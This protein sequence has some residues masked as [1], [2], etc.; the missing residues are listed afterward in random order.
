LSIPA[1]IGRFEIHEALGAG[2]MG[3]VYRAHD[4]RLDR[5]VALKVLTDGL[6]AGIDAVRRFEQEARAASSL[7]H[8]NI[9]TVFD[10]GIDGHTAYIVT[11]L[12]QGTTLRERL[13]RR[14]IAVDAMLDIAVQIAAGLSAAH[15][16]GIV[17]RDV[18]PQN[19][20]VTRTGVVK[21]LDFGVAR[22]EKA[23]DP[24]PVDDT[25]PLAS[26]TGAG[27]VLGTPAYMAPEQIRGQAADARADI[28]AFGCVLHEMMCGTGPFERATPADAMAAVLAEAPPARPPHVGAPGL[29]RIVGRC[30]EKDPTD[31]FQSAADL[32][33]ALEA[34]R[35]A[36]A[37]PP[38]SAVAHRATLPVAVLAGLALIAVAVVTGIWVSRDS[39]PPAESGPVVIHATTV[40]P[41]SAR[42]IAPAVAP[43]GK[44]VAYVG[45]AGG[46]PDV[47]V[48]YLNA[49]PPV[50]LTSGLDLPLQTR[51]V[52]GGIDVLPDGSGIAVAGRGPSGCGACLA[53]GWCR[54]RSAGRR[55]AS[56]NGMPVFVGLPTACR[57]P[58]SSPTRWWATPS[59][60][61]RP[62]AKTNA[63][64]YRRPGV[65]TFT[66]SRGGTMGG[67]CI[68][69]GR[70][71]R[72]I[73]SARSTASRW[74]AGRQ[75]PSCARRAPRS[76]RRRHRM[77]AP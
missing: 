73:P 21:L 52:V 38:P 51:T 60:W 18:K 41:A 74:R 22:L 70:W 53:S 44:W 61:R 10:A 23:A 63:S 5:E 26:D 20:F 57:S 13:S 30:L 3:V 40:V 67:T 47:Y 65:C 16:A 46:E 36:I 76:T 42:P 28:F 43:D 58:R 12:L 34:V 15:R 77:A 45:L 66:M 50:N 64:W 33:F 4:T 37:V 72:T 9:V 55:A 32:R 1:R 14:P 7:N 35:D 25:R 39:P 2:G 11:E 71:S 62:T 27:L 19:I 24:G 69:R 31:R 6:A 68:S 59:P 54:P 56:P 29:E 17:H 8:P 75:S 49:G 48:Q